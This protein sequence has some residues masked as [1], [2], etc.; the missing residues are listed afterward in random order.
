MF[1]ENVKGT[2]T[3]SIEQQKTQFAKDKHGLELM[4]DSKMKEVLVH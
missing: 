3:R 2:V 1:L 4:L